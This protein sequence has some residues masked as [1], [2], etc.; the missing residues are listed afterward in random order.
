MFNLPSFQ[1][2]DQFWP[3]AYPD[4]DLPKPSSWQRLKSWLVSLLA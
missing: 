3:M 1:S 4:C 2:T